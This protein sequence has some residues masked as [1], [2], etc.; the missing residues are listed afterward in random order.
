MTNLLRRSGALILAA[1]AI[2][3]CGAGT[4]PTAAPSQAP[5]A[6]PSAGP[7]FEPLLITRADQGGLACMDALITGKLTRHA[8]TGLAVTGPDGK[9]TPVEWPFGY[10]AHIEDGVAVL[11]DEKGNAVAREGDQIQMGGGFGNVMWHACGGVTVAGS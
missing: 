1:A 5:S 3:A 10:S 2:A 11:V 7:S 8:G 6:A 9:Q 4:G